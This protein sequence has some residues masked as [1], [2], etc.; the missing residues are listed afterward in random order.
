MEVAQK[1]ERFLADLTEVEQ[2]Y[3]RLIELTRNQSRILQ[4]GLSDA[5][6]RFAQSKSAEMSR[7]DE[8]EPRMQEG[9]GFWRAQKL[10]VSS[11]DRARVEGAIARVESVLRELVELE[12]EEQRI[13]ARRRHETAAQIRRVDNA[14]RLQSAYGST[15]PDGVTRLD[16]RE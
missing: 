3:S 14:R 8:V 6:L 13:I 9:R 4:S 16:H 7:L 10:T 15:V 2:I 1:V 11:A 12:E 5:V